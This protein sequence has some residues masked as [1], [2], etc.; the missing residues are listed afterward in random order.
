LA[1][2]AEWKGRVVETATCIFGR[3]ACEEVFAL[4]N[5]SRMAA[6]IQMQ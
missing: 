3:V 1:S 6:G 4:R 2:S 5:D